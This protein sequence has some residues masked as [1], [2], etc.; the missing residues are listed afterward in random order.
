MLSIAASL[1]QQ[2][3]TAMLLGMAGPLR[4]QHA[5]PYYAHAVLL[6]GTN[7]LR[8]VIITVQEKELQLATKPRIAGRT[9]KGV[10]WRRLM[11]A[12]QR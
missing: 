6:P 2:L 4:G 1:D 3:I 10:A 5:L 12:P 8:D 9:L 11:Q 7:T